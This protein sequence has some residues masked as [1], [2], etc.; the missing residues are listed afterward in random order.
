MLS[1]M[2]GIASALQYLHA[3][4]IVH[5]D[6]KPHNALLDADGVCKLCDMGFARRTTTAR[7]MTICGTD[8]YMAPEGAVWGGKKQ[9]KPP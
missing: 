6:V 8:E 2:H 4:G 9:G 7:P 5:R 1:L 3:V